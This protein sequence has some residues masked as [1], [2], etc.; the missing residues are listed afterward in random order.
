MACALTTG[1]SEPCLDAIGGIK[2]VYFFDRLTD[3]FTIT[4]GEATAMN[5][6]LTAAFNFALKADGNTLEEVATADSNNGTYVVDQTLTFN[7]KKQ[8]LATANEINLLAKAQPGC[9]VK[10]RDDTYRIVGLN[11]GVVVSGTSNSG[12][13]KGDFVGYAIT[14]V[15]Q[16]SAFAPTLDA[17]TVTAFEAVIS[18][19]QISV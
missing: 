6:S 14:A 19:T 13:A 15:G 18:A 9:V 1:R 4:A 11:D 5:V 16:E 17:A 3:A 2:N 7:L 10:F 12:G 8:D